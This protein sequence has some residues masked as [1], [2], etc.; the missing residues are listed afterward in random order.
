ML[1]HTALQITGSASI[2]QAVLLVGHNVYAELRVI[3]FDQDLVSIEVIIHLF[4]KGVQA[5]VG[6]LEGG[7]GVL[8]IQQHRHWVSKTTQPN[9]GD[10]LDVFYIT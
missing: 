1:R 4:Q 3:H 7:D 8:R 9:R 6:C 5:I 10:W 2:Q